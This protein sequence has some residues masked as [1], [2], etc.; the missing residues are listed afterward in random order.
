MHVYS[1]KYHLMCSNAHIA[2]LYNYT[3]I[4]KHQDHS[5]FTARRHSD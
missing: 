5:D 4:I 3:N 2:C 1:A